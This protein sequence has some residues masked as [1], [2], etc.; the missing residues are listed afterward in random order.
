MFRISK[1]RIRVNKIFFIRKIIFVKNLKIGLDKSRN[2]V[3][4]V[5]TRKKFYK[6]ILELT[7]LFQK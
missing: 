5:D 1:T 4:N 7:K 3:Q 6:T 2:I